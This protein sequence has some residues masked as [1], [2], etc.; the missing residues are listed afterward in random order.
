MFLAGSQV[1]DSQ[2]IL[3]FSAAAGREYLFE[4]SYKL[5]AYV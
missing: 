4:I 5:I 2:H 3:I 1:D